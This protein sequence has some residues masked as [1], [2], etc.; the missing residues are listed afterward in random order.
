M[1]CHVLLGNS[2]TE[3]RFQLTNFLSEKLLD[4]I[5]EKEKNNF[6]KL[7]HDEGKKKFRCW[8]QLEVFIN[9]IRWGFYNQP[10]FFYFTSIAITNLI[11]YILHMK[12]NFLQI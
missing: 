9:I 7:E 3:T 8:P 11:F 6:W 12:S 4:F 2:E 5:F 10:N 1:S